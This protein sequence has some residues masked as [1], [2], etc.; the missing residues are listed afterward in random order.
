MRGR[1][2]TRPTCLCQEHVHMPYGA[3]PVSVTTAGGAVE[4]ALCGRCRCPMLSSCVVRGVR[5]S[6]SD[7]R[8]PS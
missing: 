4:E 3:H 2:G 7:K 8:R 5:S 6:V 1:H